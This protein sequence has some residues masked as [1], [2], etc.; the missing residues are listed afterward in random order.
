M[1]D[2]LLYNVPETKIWIHLHFAQV[3]Y[4]RV[5]KAYFRLMRAGDNFL[6]EEEKRNGCSQEETSSL[7]TTK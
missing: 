4:R 2:Y 1:P 3:E 7:D 5:R 6:K